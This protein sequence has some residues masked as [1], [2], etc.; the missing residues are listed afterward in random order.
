MS[1][2]EV[3]AWFVREVLPLEAA[4]MHFLRLSRRNHGDAED[5]CQEV[6]IRIYEA[7]QKD[8][9]HDP[10]KPY[11]FTIARNLLIDRAKRDQV[12]PIQSMADLDELGIAAGEPA[13][14][15]AIMARQ[16]LMRFEIAA[17][18]PAVSLSTLISF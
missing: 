12:I 1:A 15:R 10:V 18:L 14:D 4:L 13:A 5:L 2:S 9:P 16:E 7:A 17:Y 8:I 3:N 11:L 6:Y